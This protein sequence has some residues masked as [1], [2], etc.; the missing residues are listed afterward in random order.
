MISHHLGCFSVSLHRV[1]VNIQKINLLFSDYFMDCVQ[2][3]LW[4]MRDVR[5]DPQERITLNKNC[6]YKCKW[7]RAS[8][9]VFHHTWL[10][11]CTD[12]PQKAPELPTIP[13]TRHTCT[14]NQ[15]FLMPYGEIHWIERNITDTWRKEL[16]RN[17]HRR[18][19]VILILLKSF[20]LAGLKLNPPWESKF[21]PTNKVLLN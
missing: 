7:G 21:I 2:N 11:I 18:S 1:C 8:E 19:L 10:M 20:P 17:S 6:Q 14:H 5:I 16:L 4:L 12:L 13:L 3:Y 9:C 15:V